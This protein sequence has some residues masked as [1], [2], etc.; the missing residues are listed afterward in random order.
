M[1]N[2]AQV[3]E[4]LIKQ[5]KTAPSLEEV[6]WF[7]GFLAAYRQLPIQRV[8]GSIDISKVTV[9]RGRYL[10]GMDTVEAFACPLTMELEICLMCDPKQDSNRLRQV[11]SSLCDCLMLHSNG[12][13]VSQVWCKGMEYNKQAMGYCLK[14]GAKLEPLMIRT[15]NKEGFAGIKVDYQNKGE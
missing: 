5:L 7:A 2:L 9:D 15:Q 6:E 14:A 12:I 10:G 8:R 4:E 11:F 3:V 1:E 13:A